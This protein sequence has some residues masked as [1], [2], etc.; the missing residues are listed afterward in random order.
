M[1]TGGQMPGTAQLAPTASIRLTPLSA[2]NTVNVPVAASIEVICSFPAGQSKIGMRDSNTLRLDSSDSVLA[3]S[4]TDPILRPALTGSLVNATARAYL[5]ITPR[6][7]LAVASPGCT[8][9][10]WTW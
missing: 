7:I 6:P 9:E 4:A 5:I 3:F 10:H 8:G 1:V 2:S